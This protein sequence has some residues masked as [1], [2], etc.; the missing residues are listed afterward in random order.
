MN[1][2]QRTFYSLLLTVWLHVLVF[3]RR[4]CAGT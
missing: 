2:K 3:K 1:V 4:V